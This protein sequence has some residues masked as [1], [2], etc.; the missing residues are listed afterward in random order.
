MTGTAKTPTDKGTTVINLDLTGA[1]FRDKVR[2]CWVGKNCGGTLGTP[3]EE[4][5]G[6]PEPFDVWWYPELREGG[7]PND[8]LEMQLVWLTALEQVGPDLTARDLARY[9]LDHIGYN[10][11]EY[12][13]SKTNLRL[14]LVPPVSGAF[15][16]WFVDCMGSPIRSEIWACVAPG[17]PRLAARYAYEDAICDHAGG[18]S[19]YGELFNVAIQ[20]AAFV[21]GDRRK[22]VEIGLSYV[23]EGSQ[24]AKA[25]RAALQAIDEGLDWKAARR[26]VLEA[27]P[28]HVAQYSPIN[29]G[30][31]VIGLLAAEDFGEALCITV[32]CGY[33]T[34]SSGGTIGSWWG[35]IAGDSNLPTKW[36]EPFG[37]AIST[38]ESW[39]GVRH[40]SDGTTPIPSTLPEVVDRLV[41][42]AGRVLRAKAQLEGDTIRV[43]EESLYADDEVRSLWDRDPM[44]VEFPEAELTTAVRYDGTPAVA[45]GSEARVTTRLRNPHP[46]PVRGTL[47]VNVPRGWTAP[48]EQQ[49]QIDA[50]S[51]AEVHWTIPVPARAELANSNRLF[52]SVELAG[53]PQEPA[54][55]VVLIGSTAMRTTGTIT[56]PDGA[57]AAALLDQEFEPERV[58]GR[59]PWARAGEWTELSAEGNAVPAAA[60]PQAGGVSYLQTFL[61]VD[62]EM[63]VTLGIDSGGPV[64]AWLNDAELFSLNRYRPIRPSYAGTK[65]GYGDVHLRRGWNEVLVKFARTADGE[66]GE[67]HLLVS[68]ADELHHGLPQVG[69]T[70][71]PWDV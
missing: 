42:A 60:L 71:F 20:S 61:H 41:S 27:T 65:D 25:V 58:A 9:W 40:L 32:N 13:L 49:V 43:T 39:G 8:D 53:Y 70:R 23:P 48:A 63:D 31:Q 15:N 4:A 45:P 35:I 2:G 67:C 24:T 46:D 26:R 21:V 18:E 38:N 57:D 68:S 59:E 50:A 51:T 10:W 6:R 19:V 34:D 28:H 29:M 3:V 56:A 66:A 36:T 64:K 44:L 52:V 30:F 5:L 62:E 37:D 7:L 14:G 16:N 22:L 47:R 11:D 54:T 1:V 33:D 12:G 55:P 17:M 69:R